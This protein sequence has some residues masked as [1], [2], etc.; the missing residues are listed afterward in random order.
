MI[1]GT[2]FNFQVEEVAERKHGSV[3]ELEHIKR[4]RLQ[5]RL[6]SRVTQKKKGAQRDHGRDDDEDHDGGP[7]TSEAGATVKGGSGDGKRAETTMTAAQRVVRGR[8]E[9]EYGGR[10]DKRRRPAGEEGDEALATGGSE[11]EAI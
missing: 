10:D 1:A 9:A 11:E 5:A 8:L 7:S 6:L 4:D 2:N 3:E